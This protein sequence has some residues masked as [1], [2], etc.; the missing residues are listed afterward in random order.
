M[1][2]RY[3][4]SCWDLCQCP[5]RASFGRESERLFGVE[6]RPDMGSYLN[7]PRSLTH[8]GPYGALESFGAEADY[9]PSSLKTHWQAA[10]LSESNAEQGKRRRK[11]RRQQMCADEV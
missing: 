5:F 6:G 8:F 7:A 11:P 2:W 4:R 1:H 3:A 10:K 9:L